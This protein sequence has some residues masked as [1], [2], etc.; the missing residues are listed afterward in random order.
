MLSR[1]FVRFKFEQQIS[2]ILHFFLAITLAAFAFVSERIPKITVNRCVSR[3]E[4]LRRAL[5]NIVKLI[6]SRWHGRSIESWDVTRHTFY[7]DVTVVI[8]DSPF[9]AVFSA[10]PE[11][12]V[13]KRP[14]P[15]LDDA[16]SPLSWS[17]VGAT[18][19]PTYRLRLRWR[20]TGYIAIRPNEALTLQPRLDLPRFAR[21]HT[22]LEQPD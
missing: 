7:D 14:L 22:F 13:V 8:V 3:N 4:I 6:N 18:S 5:P 10:R 2:D 12:N 20:S 15:R 16:A 17:T 21:P 11:A 9:G 19:A 1:L